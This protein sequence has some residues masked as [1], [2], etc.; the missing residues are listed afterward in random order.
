M[1]SVLLLVF[2]VL[3]GG[4]FPPLPTVPVFAEAEAF[5]DADDNWNLFATVTHEDG[6]DEVEAVWVEVGYAFYDDDDTVYTEGA[7]GDP[8]DLVPVGESNEWSAQVGSDP[9]FLDCD[10]PFEYY[11]LFIAEDDEGNQGARTVIN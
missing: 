5:C 9:D 6:D 3:L 2:L 7:I 10:Y 4:C 11:L 8:V 1:R